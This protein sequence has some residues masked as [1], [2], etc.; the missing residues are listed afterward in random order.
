VSALN[1]LSISPQAEL[2]LVILESLFPGLRRSPVAQ[3]GIL[4]G[5]TWALYEIATSL[6]KAKTEPT[7]K[8]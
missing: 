3:I 2:L 8:D 1:Y 5:T 6:R 4:F 7:G